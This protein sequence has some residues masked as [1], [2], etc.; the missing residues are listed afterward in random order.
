MC[1]V[2]NTFLN[3]FK[4][5]IIRELR[6]FLSF[7]F[8]FLS[9]HHA[10]LTEFLFCAGHWA[11]TGTSRPCAGRSTGLLGHKRRNRLNTTEAQG[12]RKRAGCQGL[13][14]CRGDIRPTT[15]NWVR[16]GHETEGPGETARWEA[17][18]KAGTMSQGTRSSCGAGRPAGWRGRRR[19]QTGRAVGRGEGF[20]VCPGA[21][22]AVE[23]L[24]A[25][26]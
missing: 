12:A 25:G 22:G 20:T 7:P 16:V 23:G 21:W 2:K 19:S 6:L 17:A 26:E 15:E 1:S 13:C 24:R 18:G 8:F 11:A 3:H 14:L 9:A 5:P 10:V 4:S